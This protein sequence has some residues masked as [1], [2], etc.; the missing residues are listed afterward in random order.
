MGDPVRFRNNSVCL[1]L[2]SFLG[3]FSS[4]YGGFFRGISSHLSRL[5]YYAKDLSVYFCIISA[6]KRKVYTSDE[7]TDIIE[8]QQFFSVY[9]CDLT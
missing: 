9:S 6:F 7:V 5:C 8:I 4:S 2:S 3:I 1:A